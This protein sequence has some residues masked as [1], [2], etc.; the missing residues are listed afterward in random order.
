MAKNQFCKGWRMIRIC[1]IAVK[2]QLIQN[3]AVENWKFRIQI[4]MAE[5]R[6]H[7]QIFNLYVVI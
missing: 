1:L 6:S 7:F 2:V 4:E 3:W 5:T